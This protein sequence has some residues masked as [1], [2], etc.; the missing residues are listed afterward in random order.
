EPAE[1]VAVL[2]RQF[3]DFVDGEPLVIGG[4]Q[5]RGYLDNDGTIILLDAFCLALRFLGCE[6]KFSGIRKLL[7]NAKALVRKVAAVQSRER[8]ADSEVCV[9]RLRFRQSTSLRWPLRRGFESRASRLNL[10]IAL[11]YFGQQF[12]RAIC[13][14]FRL[15]RRQSER[16]QAGAPAQN[17]RHTKPPQ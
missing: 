15:Q 12:S 14:I 7:R 16:E 2:L 13:S 17:R 9:T 1:Q 4:L 6:G 5:P 3:D 8:M 10:W 11:E